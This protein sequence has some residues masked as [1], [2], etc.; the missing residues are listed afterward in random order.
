MSSLERKDKSPKTESSGISDVPAI[1]FAGGL[2]TRMQSETGKKTKMMVEIEPGKPLLSYPLDLL[3]S[4]GVNKVVLSVSHGKEEIVE[5]YG[6]AYSP[7][8]RI[9]YSDQDKPTGVYDAF[10]TTLRQL[11]PNNDFFLLHGDEII[12]NVLLSKM[13]QFHQKHKGIATNLISTRNDADKI[14]IMRLDEENKV[15]FV[16]RNPKEEEKNSSLSSLGLFLFKTPI[17]EN[18]DEYTT[19]AQMVEGLVEKSQLYGYQTE[20]RFYNINTQE[21]ILRYLS[22]QG[23]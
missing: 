8:L 17:L 3:S 14:V 4:T 23:K 22:S 7:S 12:H 18:L 15:V 6:T 11:Q 13:Y 10:K 19:W 2:N 20:A 21:D 1:V 16:K 9:E 5:H